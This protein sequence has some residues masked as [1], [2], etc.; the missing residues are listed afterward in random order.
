MPNHRLREAGFITTSQDRSQNIGVVA[1]VS[2]LL[3]VDSGPGIGLW[4]P[5]PLRRAYGP[6]PEVLFSG[7]SARPLP[8]QRAEVESK[9]SCCQSLAKFV[10]Q[11]RASSPI[12]EDRRKGWIKV[13]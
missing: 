12:D 4:P 3:S 13:R 8:A 11:R 1:E 2:I 6:L 10:V 5:R 7:V 9:C